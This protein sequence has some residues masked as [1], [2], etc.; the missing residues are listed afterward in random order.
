MKN[1]L[2]IF[3]IIFSNVLIAQ[4]NEGRILYTEEV[5][6]QIDLPEEM[7]HMKDKLPSSQKS[8]RELLFSPSTSLWQ[9]AEVADNE[10]TA[11]FEDTNEEGNVRIKMIA[12]GSESKLFKDL[13]KNTKTEKTDFMGKV[14]L[15]KGDLKQYP[16]KLSGASKTI[17]GYDCQQAIF[18]DSSRNIEAWFTTQIPV[19][20]GPAE[21]GA[22]PGMILELNID[23]GQITI[24]AARV[25]LKKLEADA[26][27]APKKGKKVSQEEYEAIVE[28]KTKEMEEEM[29]GSG[30]RIKIRQ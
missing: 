24:S 1:L 28:A 9:A 12:V 21:Y 19:S 22:L 17:A 2:L 20:S 11:T 13:D 16:W 15:I 3:T 6:F 26:I 14:F 5:K 30:M 29:G 10:D 7:A 25:E 4:N 27:Q 8:E 23:N 18:Q